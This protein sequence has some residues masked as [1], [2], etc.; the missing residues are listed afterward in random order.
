WSSTCAGEIGSSRRSWK[1]ARY[2][3]KRGTAAWVSKAEG[4]FGTARKLLKAKPLY[5]DQICFHCQQAAEKYLKALLHELRLPIHHTHD[6]TVLVEQLRPMDATL[7][8]LRRSTKTLTRYAVEYRYP[9]IRA[10]S[11]QARVAYEK[12]LRFREEVRKRL[13]LPIHRT[14]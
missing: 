14:K 8:S 9:G 5:T 2:F 13:G 7:R 10:T 11:R 6:S 4:D 12:A 1:R 3:M